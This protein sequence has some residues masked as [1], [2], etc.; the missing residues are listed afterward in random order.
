[1]LGVGNP[2]AGDDAI[3]IEI[4]KRLKKL[5]LPR[6]VDVVEGGTLSFQLINFFDNYD[7]IVVVDAVKSGKKPGS[8]VRIE[9][10][11]FI[12]SLS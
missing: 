2:L 12:E 1:M 5:K 8:V 10:K 7:K 9:M 3:G 4:V 6:E 11:D